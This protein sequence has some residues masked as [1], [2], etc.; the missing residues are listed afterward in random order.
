MIAKRQ[1]SSKGRRQEYSY[2]PMIWVRDASGRRQVWG[3][4][5]HTKAEAKMAE[6][7]LLQE[8]DAGAD[9]RRIKLTI[10]QAFDQYIAEKRSKVKA[11]TLQRSRELLDNLVPLV[12][13]V[14]LTNLKPADISE[15]YNALLER[16]AKRTVRHCHWQLHGALALAV[17]WG[18][19]QVNVAARVKPPVPEAFEGQALSAADVG[20]LLEAVR[21]RP[22]AP[23]IM[24]AIDSGGRQGELL[25]LRWSDLDFDSGLI[26]IGRSVRRLK[27]RFEFTEPKTRRS[28]RAVEVSATTVTAL[29]VHRQ[30]QL[31]QRL[32]AGELW[33][34]LDLV[35]AN[36]TG[37]PLDGSYVSRVFRQ[38][39]SGIGLKT[40]RF[41]D[42]RHSSVSLLLKNGESMAEVS[43]RAGHS[44]I[45]VTVDTYGH[46]MGD[47]KSLAETMGAILEKAVTDPATWLANG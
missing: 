40:M 16:L 37:S 12:G 7:R 10:A 15:A 33:T 5:Y 36:E 13:Q 1:R 3:G 4:S 14:Q 39:A 31:E 38:I 44:S 26:H 47:A 28:R 25:A 19:T 34:N 9:L 45:G 22:M 30:R 43:R 23:L 27:G 17:Q 8:R 41:H 6:H 29:K 32:R 46:Q 20:R 35:F 42:L 11:S 24:L 2:C 18:Q 21:S